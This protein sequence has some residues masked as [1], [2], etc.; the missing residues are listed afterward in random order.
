MVLSSDQPLALVFNGEI[1]NAPELRTRLTGL[2][3]AFRST[4]DTEV[5]LHALAVWGVDET[6]ARIRGM[7]AFIVWDERDRSITA[8]TDHV[9]M[10]PLVFAV[11]DG[12]FRAASD[13]DALRAILPRRPD[14]DPQA[15][16]HVV[17]LGYIPAPL[18]IWRDVRKLAPGH[19][20]RWTADHGV[21]EHRYWSPP[22]FIADG[23]ADDFA[24]VWEPIVRQHLLSDV[25]IGTFLSAGLDS[26][27]VALALKRLG[28]HPTCFSLA[29]PSRDD[30][31]LEAAETARHLG[32]PFQAVA[33]A[34]QPLAETLH[35]TAAAFDEPQAYT[36]LLTQVSLCRA[37]R[38]H[39][40][41]MLTGDGGD[42]AFGGYIWHRQPPVTSQSMRSSADALAAR[43][44]RPDADAATRRAA[45]DALASR[46]FVHAFLQA[47]LP[48]FHPAEARA[49]F[50]PLSP[51]YDDEIYAAPASAE[52]APWLPWPRRAQRLD[53]LT[54]CAGSILPK[55][56]RAS[57]SVG[58]ELRCPFLD[59]RM[60]EWSL[61]RPGQPDEADPARAKPDVRAYLQGHVPERV[62]TR[63]KQGFSLRMRQQDPWT[64]LMPWF[65]TTRLAREGVLHE[66]WRAFVE[67]DAPYAES[68]RF[69]LC[70]L[71]AWAEE[72]I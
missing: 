41:V 66:Q 11:G 37:T 5:L 32:L 67:R 49:L 46:S 71:A 39:A 7:Y 23:P 24:E 1:Y 28:E 72:R 61:R 58:L 47:V 45:L 8:A 62:L 57:M 44:A 52:D 9:G 22:S 17:S 4:A 21:R 27:T 64:N 20:V 60:L 34:D 12:V 63:Q 15:L 13:A 26:S 42:E 65:E 3:C 35:Q 36:A 38:T 10:K 54:F 29:L 2:G 14:L 16:C 18:T 51:E 19:V 25:P 40:K 70:M 6:L 59:R 55:I 43:A 48:R 31:S 68:R 50:A 56:D 30:E 53:L 33:F 69:I